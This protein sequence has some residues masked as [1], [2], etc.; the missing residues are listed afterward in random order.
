MRPAKLWSWLKW[1]AAIALFAWL[2]YHNRHDLANFARTEKH[3]GVLALAFLACG[4]ATMLTFVRWHLLVRALGIPFRLLDAFRLGF[5][6]LVFHYVGTGLVGADVVKAAFIAREQPGRRAAAAATVFLDRVL[7]LLA[8]FLL[9]ACAAAI[10]RNYP[11]TPEFLAVRWI[12]WIGAASGTVGL[13]LLLWP[14]F[15]HS[16]AVGLLARLPVAGKIFVELLEDVKLYQSRPSV[17]IGAT[18][19]GLISHSLLIASFYFCALG[20]GGWA[21]SVLLHF[22]FMPLAE[23]VSLIPTAGV[24][25]LAM[26]ESYGFAAGAEVSRQAAEASGLAAALAFRVVNLLVCGLGGAVFAGGRRPADA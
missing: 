25:E 26:S 21:P 11:Q 7:G 24:L 10:S 16:R 1:P 14:A 22:S 23:L 12:L 19:L 15:T 4:G 18:L 5:L 3:Y 17:L 13:A 20:L 2:I 6:G 8:L 9:G